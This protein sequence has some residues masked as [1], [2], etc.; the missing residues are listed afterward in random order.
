MTRNFN[1]HCCGKQHAE[2]IHFLLCSTEIYSNWSTFSY[3]LFSLHLQQMLCSEQWKYVMYVVFNLRYYGGADRKWISRQINSISSEWFIF[4]ANNIFNRIVIN[5]ALKFELW[6][7]R[8]CFFINRNHSNLWRCSSNQSS[9][10]SSINIELY[11][12]S[13][14]IFSNSIL[15]QVQIVYSH[16]VDAKTKTIHSFPWPTKK[17]FPYTRP[18]IHCSLLNKNGQDNLVLSSHDHVDIGIL[19]TPNDTFYDVARRHPC[20]IHPHSIVHI[21]VA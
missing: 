11:C 6:N 13:I 18:C 20:K 21:T 5:I 4:P 1:L 8:I 19:R 12:K 9:C 14:C 3:S 15:S 16:S 17:N 10:F 2:S 7:G